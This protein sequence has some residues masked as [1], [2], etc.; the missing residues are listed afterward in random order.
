MLK[1]DIPFYDIG[2]SYQELKPEIDQAI[3]KVL[4]NGW[5]ILGEEVTAFEQEFARY[6]GTRNCVGVSN[7]LD[8]LFLTLKAWGIG[9]GDEVIVPSNT[10]IA[11]WL[12]VSYSGATPVPVE[13]DI[14][15]F[16]L[17]P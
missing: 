17:D 12:A 16:H 2:Q 10:Y 8:A 13:P 5:Y 4:S 14:N 1:P 15:T 7:G 3:S 6:I 9:A 11:T